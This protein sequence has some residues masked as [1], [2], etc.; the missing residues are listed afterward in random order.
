M[1]WFCTSLASSDI[2]APICSGKRWCHED[3]CA[4][5]VNQQS[6]VVH[7]MGVWCINGSLM[8]HYRRGIWA[9]TAGLTLGR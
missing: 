6:S 5:V 7:R 8:P 9:L 1:E 4:C 2:V 3:A